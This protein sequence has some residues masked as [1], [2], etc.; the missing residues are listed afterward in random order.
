MARV[1]VGESKMEDIAREQLA[2]FIIVRD[3]NPARLVFS[4]S[5][6]TES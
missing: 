3:H 1:F 4:Q 5:V 6:V 2:L